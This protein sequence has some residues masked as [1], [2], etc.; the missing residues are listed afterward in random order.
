MTRRFTP[1]HEITI[2]DRSTATYRIIPVML[3]DGCGYTKLEW[4]ADASADWELVD[5]EW[6][7]Q[8]RRDVARSVR[9]IGRGSDPK[10][11]KPAARRSFRAT[12]DEWKRWTAA[13]K[14]VDLT[15]SDWLRDAAELAI[16]RGSTR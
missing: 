13:A 12:D 4:D 6:L 15:I 10:R 5:G 9:R 1:T 16:A 2:A 11:G 7:F 3:V 14:R 8:G